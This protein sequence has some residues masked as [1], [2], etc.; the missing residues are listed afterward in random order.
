MDARII[1][2]FDFDWRFHL[3]DVPGAEERAYPD[4]SWRSVD[5]PHDWSI[6]GP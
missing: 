6:E 1:Q 4:S 5:L 3:G 2:C